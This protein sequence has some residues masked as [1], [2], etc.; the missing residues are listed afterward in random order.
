MENKIS[1]LS[2]AECTALRGIAILGIMLHNY[3]HWLR[4]A[5]KEN[6]YTFSETNNDRLLDVL[7]HP[8]WN[9]PIHLLS[10]FGHY[11]V[12]VFLFLSGYGLVMKYE[13]SSLNS[14]ISTLHFT[15]Y[16]YLKLFRMMIVGYIFFVIVDYMTP[17]P[18]H[19]ALLDVVSQLLMFNNLLPTPDKVIWPG[20]FWF[21]GLM[22][23]LYIVYRLLVFRRHWCIV[24]ALIVVCWVV[25]LPFLS[26]AETL[27]RLR[28]NCISG[29]LPFGLGIIVARLGSRLALEQ[30]KKWQWALVILAALPLTLALC[31][32][33]QT[34]L[35]VPIMILIAGI[36]LVK[37]TPKPVLNWLIWTGGI[38]AA[39]FVAHP[40][41]RK[42]LIPISHRGDIYAGLLLYVVATFVVS[43]LFMLI[44]NRMPKPKL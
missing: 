44:I 28:Y 20:P 36:A 31:L 25:Q 42:V 2:H 17:G 14:P 33:A 11:G 29:M 43:W 12:P 26:D 9:L 22:M 24:V 35:W 8:D 4:M 16:N 34:W 39:M 37:L 41:L 21:F 13:N 38:S 3:C 27:N 32:T 19:Y 1:L 10:Y 6:E 15:K 40:T 23:Q 18:H 30:V 7:T 5:V